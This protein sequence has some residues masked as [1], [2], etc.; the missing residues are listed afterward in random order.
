MGAP[1]ECTSSKGFLVAP[2][3]DVSPH[4]LLARLARVCETK[5]SGK[6]HVT[7]EVSDFWHKA[8][9][10]T[11]LLM[12]QTLAACNWDKACLS[13]LLMERLSKFDIHI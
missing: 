8:K 6:C 3:Q 12:G 2:C 13:S 10:A 4:A 7:P 5:D 1:R 11:K 9:P